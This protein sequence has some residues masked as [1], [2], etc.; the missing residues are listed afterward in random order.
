MSHNAVTANTGARVFLVGLVLQTASYV[1]FLS[2]ALWAHLSI[3]RSKESTGRE[4][5]WKIIWLIYFSSIFILVSLLLRFSQVPGLILYKMRCVYRIIEGT[6][7]HFYFINH[8]SNS[9]N[10][11][12]KVTADIC[13]PTRVNITPRVK[14][15]ML[16]L[17]VHHSIFLSPRHPSSRMGHWNLW[18]LLA[19]R[20]PELWLAVTD[21]WTPFGSR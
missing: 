13:L 14:S 10:K 8:E 18:S 6:T 1:I 9:A 4:P 3:R 7:F 12:C 21:H 15:S 20:S 5:W 17:C 11:E 19:K 2:M 16:I